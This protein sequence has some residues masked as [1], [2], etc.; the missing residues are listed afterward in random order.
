MTI[1]PTRIEQERRILQ[2]YF[3][4]RFVFVGLNTD[5]PYVDLGLQSNSKKVYRIRI[6]LPLDYPN[7]LP[8]VFMTLPKP[9]KKYD[10]SAMTEVSHAMHTLSPSNGDVQICHYKAENWNPNVTLYRIVLKVRIWIEAYEGHLRT[11]EDIDEF[12]NS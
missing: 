2:T 11:G 3:P 9:L 8:E 1:N 5:N 6:E 4:K 7:S 12:L 10:G